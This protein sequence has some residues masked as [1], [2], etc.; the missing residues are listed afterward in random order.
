MIIQQKLKNG[1]QVDVS[2]Y[3][4]MLM[5]GDITNVE[6]EKL[7]FERTGQKLN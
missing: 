5:Q 4:L 6:F 1:T 3:Y 2:D 7:V